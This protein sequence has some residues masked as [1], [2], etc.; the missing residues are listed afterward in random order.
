MAYL[1]ALIV[2]AIA[3]DDAPPH[4]ITVHINYPDRQLETLLRLFDGA[5]APDPASALAAWRRATGNTKTPGKAIEAAIAALNPGMIREL[6]SIDA[7]EFVLDFGAE[8]GEPRWFLRFPN[9][10]GTFAAFATAMA[11]SGGASEPPLRDVEVDRL[12][13]AGSPL[14]GRRRKAAKPEPVAIAGLREDL[15]A[16]F[17]NMPD[18]PGRKE[19]RSEGLL[20]RMDPERLGRSQSVP[21]RQAA[22]MLLGMGVRASQGY[23]VLQDDEVFPSRLD[24]IVLSKIEGPS[25]PAYIDPK[26][27]EEIPGSASAVFM[28]AF[29]PR[30]EMWDAT[31]AMLD[32]VQKADPS[33]AKTAPIRTRLNLLA[34]AAG[35]RPEVDLWP[36]LR[37]ISG[38]VFVDP[39]APTRVESATATLHLSDESAA[40]KIAEEFAPKVAKFLRLVPGEG[41]EIRTLGRVSGRPLFLS[42]RGAAVWI[43]W[44]E[45]SLGKVGRREDSAH[46]LLDVRIP[47]HEDPR[48][49]RLVAVWPGRAA[50]APA[51]SPLA[52]GLEGSPPVVWKGW[53]GPDRS[54]DRISS[55]DLKPALQRF[56]ERLPMKPAN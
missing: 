22:Q 21:A 19:N 52:A 5:H 29:D 18:P 54:Y 39:R 35:V 46:F 56:L 2:L 31:F 27:L 14:M 48:V 3:P 25:F 37:G 15:A 33:Q 4:A 26:W 32:R 50:I 43:G 41:G 30:P 49:S 36:K 34:A 40:K 23:L 45:K 47:G 6:R 9:D 20:I 44:G 28:I 7:G 38:H 17:L 42:R 1:L 53:T 55:P 24:L 10:D 8:K 51:G 16:A 11:L 12:G 13:P